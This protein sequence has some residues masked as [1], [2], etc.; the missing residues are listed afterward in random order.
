[1]PDLSDAKKGL[2]RGAS[3][4]MPPGLANL[5]NGLN[6]SA[7]QQAMMTGAGGSTGGLGIRFICSF[8][9]PAISICAMIMLSITLSLLN[10]FLGWMA[11]IKIC[12]PLP[13]KK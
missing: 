6:S 7:A 2:A 9:L 5:M 12:L 13:V 4:D 10:I 11:W 1:M 8:S 3:F